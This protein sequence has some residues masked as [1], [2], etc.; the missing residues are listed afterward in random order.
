MNYQRRLKM[1]PLW[2]STVLAGVRK[3]NGE[4]FLGM[5]DMYGLKIEHNY[6]LTGLSN[7]YC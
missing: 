1:N 7:Y 5:T 6:I 4:V 2:L 3:D